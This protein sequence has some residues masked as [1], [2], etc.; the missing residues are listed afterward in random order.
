MQRESL[1]PGAA[2]RQLTEEMAHSIGNALE[3]ISRAAGSVAHFYKTLSMGGSG[4]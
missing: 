2:E 4:S 3:D 1:L